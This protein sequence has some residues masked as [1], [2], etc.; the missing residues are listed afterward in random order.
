MKRVAILIDGGFPRAGARKAGKTY[1]PSF[2]EQFALR[3]PVPDE[4][5][6]RV[7]YYDCAPTPEPLNSPFLDAAIPSMGPTSG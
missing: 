1:N 3:C 2:I 7:L 6:I 5:V 4:E